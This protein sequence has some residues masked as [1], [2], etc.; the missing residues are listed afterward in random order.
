MNTVHP[1]EP[2]YKV[3]RNKILEKY[4]DMTYYSPLPGERELCE[5]FNVSR[6]TV[7]KALELLEEDKKIQRIPGKGSFYLGNK[8]HVDS[9]KDTGINFYREVEARGQYTRSKVLIQNMETASKEVAARLELGPGEKVF[10][11]ERLRYINEELY[12]LA[13]A[14]LPIVICPELL[15][16]DF[17]TTSLYKTVEKNGIHPKRA[18]KS[19]EIKPANAYEALHLGLNEGD[20]ISVMKTVTYDADGFIIEY[21]ISKSL[22]YKTRYEMVAYQV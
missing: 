8:I 11:L 4:S 2:K 3:L 19:L 18:D 17:T 6:P 15:R 10:H 14:Y 21:A 13:D 9:S 12:S 1:T 7:R 16:V 5:I 22:A 20:P